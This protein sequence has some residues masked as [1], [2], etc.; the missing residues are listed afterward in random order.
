[1]SSRRFIQGHDGPIEI[2]LAK[3]TVSKT[4]VFADRQ[5]ALQAA[6]REA[7]RS[8]RLFEA[9]SRAEGLCCPQI[10]EQNQVAPPRIVM[11]LCPGEPLS[12]FLAHT[13]KD[14]PRLSVIAA[15]IRAGVKIYVELFGEPYF[16]LCFRNILYDDASALVSF[17]DFGIPDRLRPE[18]LQAPLEASLGNLV[19]WA[20]YDMTR[21]SRLLSPRVGYLELMRCILACFDGEVSRDG[22]DAAARATFA[23]L[24]QTGSATRITYYRTAGA[25]IND[26][27]LKRLGL[28]SAATA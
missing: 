1:M 27:W 14:D 2:D 7:T 13:G 11:T 16:D 18:A 8:G 15:R 25:V 3:R 9:F 23:R 26:V 21:P 19:G 12:S 4:Y 5:R 6:H 17:L 28:R 10:L 24:A 20:C 22:I